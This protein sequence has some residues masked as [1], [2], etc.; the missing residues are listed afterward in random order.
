MDRTVDNLGATRYFNNIV[1]RSERV[2][3]STSNDNAQVYN[4][5]IVNLH[6][7]VESER[8]LPGIVYRNNLF[9]AAGPLPNSDPS[10]VR[11]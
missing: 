4:N 3:I 10:G 11:I 6:S 9:V 5:T 7:A 1:V 8:A 2:G